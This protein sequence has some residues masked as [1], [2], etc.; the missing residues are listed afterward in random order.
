[1]TNEELVQKYQNGYHEAFDDLLTNNEGIIRFMV[2]KWFRK[3][4]E[5]KITKED[6]EAECTLGFYNA[7]RTYNPDK[8]ATFSS[9]AFHRIQWHLC[10]EFRLNKP[11]TDTGEEIT[12]CSLDAPIPETD[13]LVVGDTIADDCDIE[14]EVTEKFRCEMEYP[15]IWEAVNELDC[16]C[17]DII[18]KRYKENKTLDNVAAE[19]K[20][21]RARIRQI[22]LKALKTL[23]DMQRVKDLV[24]TFDYECN[25]AYHYGVQR[26]KSTFMSSVE[27]VVFRKLELE[28]KMQLIEAEL[29]NILM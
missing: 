2:K 9:Y 26:F 22:E 12:I 11:K 3:V 25:S 19:F 14:E 1:M 15:K 17:R 21:T 24:D 16:R 8:G 7:V 27:T 4:S 5:N 28:E 29:N 20:I 10:R 18:Y 6:L 23:R 13:D